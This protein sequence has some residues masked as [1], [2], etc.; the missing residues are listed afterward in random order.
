MRKMF[1]NKIVQGV[2]TAIL[3]AISLA[4]LWFIIDMRDF[5][6][7]KQPQRDEQQDNR[8]EQTRNYIDTRCML[9]DST[10]N[11]RIYYIHKRIDAQKEDLF[12]IENKIDKILL[13]QNIWQEKKYYN[14]KL[15]GLH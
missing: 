15:I 6:K 14:Q 13:N 3:T 11:N 12:R 7:Y 1:E 5:I 10:Y 4:T 9:L 8:I 2:L